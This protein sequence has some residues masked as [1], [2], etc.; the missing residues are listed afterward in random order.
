MIYVVL[1]YIQKL[2]ITLKES[3]VAV[4]EVASTPNFPRLLSVLSFVFS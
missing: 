2:G 4:L 1:I 3:C